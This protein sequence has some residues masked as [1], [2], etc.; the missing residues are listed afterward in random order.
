MMYYPWFIVNYNDNLASGSK[1]GVVKV[2][3]LKNRL[4]SYVF[5]DDEV[6]RIDFLNQIY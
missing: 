6:S 4:S 2:W 1:E 3:N 5:K